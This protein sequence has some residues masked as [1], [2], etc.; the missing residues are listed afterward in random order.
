MAEGGSNPVR[1]NA[2]GY[3]QPKKLPMFNQIGSPLTHRQTEDVY[4]VVYLVLGS[5]VNDL[6]FCTRFPSVVWLRMA[7]VISLS[8]R[9]FSGFFL[10]IPVYTLLDN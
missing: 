2:V 4:K 7:R 1:S 6:K 8:A 3:Y 10:P 9:I 5:R